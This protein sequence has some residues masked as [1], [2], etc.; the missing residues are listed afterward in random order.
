LISGVYDSAQAL[1]KYGDN[2]PRPP[3]YGIYNVETFI[4]K[5]D[6]LAP[7]TTD[8]IRWKQMIIDGYQTN[9]WISIRKMTE[10]MD[11][12]GL[13]VDTT[14]KIITIKGNDGESKGEENAK[15]KF[16]YAAA[17]KDGFIMRGKMD[18]DSMEIRMHKYDMKKLLLVNRGFRWINEYPFNR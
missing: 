4:I 11:Y 14:T 7:L 8:S 13:K 3:L 16:S 17:D 5:N 9:S 18:G 12:Y 1:K 6:T 15:G 2:S 10:K